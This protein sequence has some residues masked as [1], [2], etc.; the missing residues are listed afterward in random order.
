VVEREREIQ[1]FTPEE[2]WE[3]HARLHQADKTPVKAEVIRCDNDKVAFPDRASIDIALGELQPATYRVQTVEAKESQ[4]RPSAPFITSTLQQAASVRLSFGVKKTMTLAQRLYEAGFITYM[5]TDA[6]SLSPEAVAMAREHIAKTYG[7]EFVPDKPNVYGSREGAQ[8]AHEAIRPTDVR[9][10]P[11]DLAGA[12]PDAQRLYDLIRRQFIACQMKPAIYDVTTAEIIAGRWGL[13]ARG[14]VVRFPGWTAV[15]PPSRSKDDELAELPPLKA[16]EILALDSL[17]PTQHFTKPPARYTEASLVREMEKRGIGRPSTYAATISTIQDRGYVRMDSRRLFAEKMGE[18]VTDRLVDSF[19]DLLDYGFTAGMENNLDQVAQ[20]RADWKQELDRFYAGFTQ[21]LSAA[22]TGMRSNDPT[23]TGIPCGTCGR[24]MMLRT[25][26]TGV[27]LG[28]SG[29]NLPPKER[30]TATM[31]LTPGEESVATTDAE[32]DEGSAA[33][34]LALKNKRR[35]Q[36]CGTAMDSWLIDATRRLHVCGRHPDCAGTAIETGSFRIKGYE[37][38]SL[39]CDKCGS[40]MELKTGRFGKFFGCTNSTCK[41][42]RKLLRNGQ[43]A[44]PRAK[45]VAMPELPCQKGGH[46]VLRDGAQGLFLASNLYPK[47]RETRNPLVR[48][49]AAHRAELDPKHQHLADAPAS[50][51]AGNPAILRWS[52]KHAEQY[53]NSETDGKASG[54]SAWWRNGQWVATTA[55]DKE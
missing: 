18:I 34:A 10:E 16:G 28:C 20:G 41:N 43:A 12:E 53:V 46:F 5:R 30:C 1:A 3:L 49:L 24:E 40:P 50:D 47:V 44:P 54:W 11:A 6:V 33:E 36:L 17:D 45:A 22:E 2:Y 9:Q 32:S 35:C 25:G 48:E 4:S 15:L 38:P 55:A 29:Y 14:R 37:G 23:A 21:R 39:P 7:S 19:P 26:R 8:E 52:R 51:P 42:T 13:R 31:N 27:F